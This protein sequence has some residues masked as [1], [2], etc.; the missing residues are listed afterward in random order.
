[1]STPQETG[2]PVD[3]SAEVR[4]ALADGGPVVALESTIITHGMPFPANAQ[5]AAE[6]E[7]II[8]DHGAV[9]AT[10]AV[11]EGRLK[12]G[13]SDG[14]RDAL[15][16]TRG[17]MKLSRADLAFAVAERRTGG[18]TVAATMIIAEMAGIAVPI[19]A[20]I[21]PITNYTQLARF[22]DQCGAELPRWLR[23]RLAAFGETFWLLSGLCALAL[24]AAW[25][26]RD[27]A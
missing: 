12:I 10:I 5:M 16:Q 3:M 8:R 19:V 1:M 9:P 17:A 20:G 14:E 4:S 27:K 6:V 11:M 15:A 25:R 22:S 21:M 2:L 7:Q 18:T 13:L 24:V 23:L 26:L